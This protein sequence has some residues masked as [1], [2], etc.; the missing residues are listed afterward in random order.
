M[1]LCSDCG[2]EIIHPAKK[3]LK[4]KPCR[5]KKRY[6]ERA[7]DPR[8]HWAKMAVRGARRRA[9]CSFDWRWLKVLAERQ[10]GLCWYCERSLRWLSRK[11]TRLSPTL[12]KIIPKVGYHKDNVV[13]ACR[14]CNR[15]KS[16]ANLQELKGIVKGLEKWKNT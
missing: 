8:G 7:K 3:S 5:K 9:E 13:I 11:S 6:Q 15:I 16:D 1:K 2:N 4:C 14:R 10:N 12:D